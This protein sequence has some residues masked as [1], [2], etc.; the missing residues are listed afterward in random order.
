MTGSRCNS[1]HTRDLN[2][3][4][5]ADLHYHQIDAVSVIK[6]KTLGFRQGVV[7]KFWSDCISSIGYPKFASHPHDNSH[8]P[9]KTPYPATFANSV[10]VQQKLTARGRRSQYT[11]PRLV[12]FALLVLKGNPLRSKHCHM[13]AVR[14]G[15]GQVGN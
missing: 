2:V 15:T 14:A 6:S 10:W 7:S 9:P 1:T 4:K 3:G 8:H 5:F 11:S 12:L 13:W